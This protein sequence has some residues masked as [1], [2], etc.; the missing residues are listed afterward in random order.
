MFSLS[1][2]FCFLLLFCSSFRVSSF[3]VERGNPLVTF[4]WQERLVRSQ[5]GRMWRGIKKSRVR[6]PWAELKQNLARYLQAWVSLASV[7]AVN[8]L[9]VFWNNIAIGIVVCKKLWEAKP[10]FRTGQLCF[11]S[12]I[13]SPTLAFHPP[14]GREGG[15]IYSTPSFYCVLETVLTLSKS[16]TEIGLF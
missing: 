9:A 5:Q 2:F 7:Y 13:H 6:E 3:W 10:N 16:Q 8:V 14:K 4:R 15:P 1:R 11:R 12:R